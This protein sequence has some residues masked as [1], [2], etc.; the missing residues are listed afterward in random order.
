MQLN[1]EYFIFSLSIFMLIIYL[2]IPNPHILFKLN[3]V[4]NKCIKHE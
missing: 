4:I 2:V 1:L 3:N